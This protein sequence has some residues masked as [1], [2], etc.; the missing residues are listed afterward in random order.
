[1]NLLFAV[2][3]GYRKHLLHCVN[4][5]VRFPVEEGY[6][7]YILFSDWSAENRCDFMKEVG[8]RARVHFVYVDQKNFQDFP[9]SK[10]Y[11]HIIYYRIFAAKFLPENVDR[12]LY[13]D[14]DVIVIRSLEGLYQTDFEGNLFCACTHVRSFLNKMNQ[15][16]L[17]TEEEYSYINSGMLLMNLDKLREVLNFQEVREYVEKRRPRLTLPDQDIITALYG[18]RIKLLDSMRY[19][20]S[21]RMILVNNSTPGREKIDLE[22]VKKH[23]VIIHYYGKNKPWNENYKGILDVFYRQMLEETVLQGSSTR[24]TEPFPSSLET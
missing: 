7:I 4:S 11:P 15:L 14:T 9:V 13:L 16:R 1:M 23:G 21:D 18:D 19:N 6:D 2:D 20:L 12:V 10:R 3:Q 22:W 5:I 24:N 17:G 8:E